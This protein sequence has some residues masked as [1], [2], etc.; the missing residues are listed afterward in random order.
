V[1]EA[2]VLADGSVLLRGQTAHALSFSHRLFAGE[3]D[4]PRRIPRSAFGGHCA[5][6]V[7]CG[8]R[9]TLVLSADGRAWTAGCNLYAQLGYTAA[10]H[11]EHFACV[12]GNGLAEVRLVAAACGD[13]HNAVLD[14]R[15]R[16]WTWGGVDAMCLG[17]ECERSKHVP[18]ALPESAFCRDVVHSL[19]AGPAHTVALGA[20]GCPWVWGIGGALGTG[21]WLPRARPSQ[22]HASAFDGAHVTA[23]ACGGRHTLYL[24]AEGLVWTTESER[25]VPVCLGSAVLGGERAAAIAACR[26][27]SAVVTRGGLLYTWGL[28]GLPMSLDG[29]FRYEV[30]RFPTRADPVL[31][32][33]ARLG[34]TRWLSE[35]E[36][37]ALA[38]A[39][40]PRLGADSAMHA[41]DTELL[42][43]LVRVLETPAG[44]G[45]CSGTR[46][47]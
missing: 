8:K 31:F 12:A 38:M 17:R 26:D 47:R 3:H 39:L 21:D 28:R 36:R 37:L 44:S 19:A 2:A 42:L 15:G 43:L 32:A 45:E 1:H 27:L 33:G 4:R 11:R 7:A 6:V 41:L 25:F 29:R 34:T 46:T 35:A 30:A 23:V 10:G 18:C 13:V 40:H 22:L 20:H 9:H 5:V 14:T 24:D 16:V